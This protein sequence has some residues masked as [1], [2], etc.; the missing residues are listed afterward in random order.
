MAHGCFIAVLLTELALVMELPK[1]RFL[2]PKGEAVPERAARCGE[3]ALRRRLNW[4]YEYLSGIDF[5]VVSLVSCTRAVF[6]KV[7]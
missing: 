4:W 7:R 6:T 3:H 5:T 1:V 2:L